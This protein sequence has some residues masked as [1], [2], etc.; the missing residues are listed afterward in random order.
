[1][2]K[3]RKH[4]ILI[5]VLLL[6]I[7]SRTFSQ[8]EVFENGEELYYEV[9]YS[10]INIGWAKFTTEK[11][12][13]KEY[14]YIARAKLKSNT[15]L[16]LI[17]VDYDFISEIELKGGRIIPHKFTAYQYKSGK[18]LTVNYDFHYDS[19]YVYI[20]KVNY[21]NVT[22]VDKKIYTS[23]KFQDGLSI[24]Y[25]AR[26]NANKN[27]SQNVPVIMHVDTALLRVNF[28]DKK[29]AVE[30]SESDYDISS[31]FLDG[32][33]YFEGVFGLTGAFS[34]WFSSDAAKIPLKA[35]L[36]VEIGSITLELKSW[37]RRAWQ[38]PKYN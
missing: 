30:I 34:G 2:L 4:G 14:Y 13:G 23:T 6:L 38:P 28:S 37:K 5:I 9:Y 16:P 12:S 11:V 17:D 7:S 31:V 25:Y 18:Q 1:M 8:Q 20:K 32:N 15:S 35:K 29:T 21:D 19:N 36:E 24:F 10:F 33:L 22:E 27:E 26:Y 3:V